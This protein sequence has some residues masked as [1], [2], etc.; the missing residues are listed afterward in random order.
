MLSKKSTAKN[1]YMKEL[2]MKEVKPILF[3][4][5]EASK[6]SKQTR[7][8]KKKKKDHEKRDKKEQTLL[9]TAN[10]IEVKKKKKKNQDHDI[11]E[12]TCYNCSKKDYYTN[13][14]TKPKN[15]HWSWQ[16]SCQ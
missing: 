4:P 6:P 1:F 7:K 12:I 11:N 14:Y 16:P 2:K 3:Q 10:S 5:I 8:E 13:T 9:S 15:Y